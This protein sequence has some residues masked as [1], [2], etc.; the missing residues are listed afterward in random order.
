[1][2]DIIA[3]GAL[4]G[5]GTRAVAKI[6]IEAGVYMGALLNGPLDN[7]MFTRLF[8]NPNWYTKTGPEEI[9]RR[10]TIF[11]KYMQHENLRMD[12]LTELV[13]ATSQS[14]YFTNDFQFYLHL[15]FNAVKTK[16]PRWGWK[17]P[18]TQFFVPEIF[19]FFPK[20]KYIHVIRHG[21]DMAFSNNTNQLKN[22]GFKFNIFLNGNETQNDIAR[23]QLDFWIYST[24]KA[25]ENKKKFGDRFYLLNHEEFYKKPKLE[26]DSLLDF[27]YL[28]IS[29]RHKKKLYLIPQKPTSAGRYKNYDLNMFRDDQIEFVRNIGFQ[30]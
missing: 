11:K 24:Q 6:F 13:R 18:N 28:T 20:I 10:L 19:N 14:A 9:N 23:K 30:I 25:L 22:W 12:E 5:S 21:L 7:L 17:E 26:I 2:N 3:I 16:E 1:M 15:F 4:G 27:A 29:P 8:M